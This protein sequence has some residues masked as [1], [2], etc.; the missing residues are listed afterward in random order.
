MFALANYIGPLSHRTTSKLPL[1]VFH[2]I[3]AVVF[4]ILKLGSLWTV[5]GTSEGK[6]FIL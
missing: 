3:H 5:D 1:G 2:K 4:S 6:Y